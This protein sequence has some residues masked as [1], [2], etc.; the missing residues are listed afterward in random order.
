MAKTVI[1]V[2]STEELHFS[3]WIDDCLV[4]SFFDWSEYQP[5]PF[6]LSE[7][8]WLYSG[9]GKKIHIYRE[10]SY[11]PDFKIKYNETS[12]RLFDRVFKGMTLQPD[13]DFIYVDVKGEFVG[14]ANTSGIT[15]P[16]NQKWM[17]QKFGIIVY[18]VI[19]KKFFLKTW[20]PEQAA[21]KRGGLRRKPYEKCRLINEF[22][23]DQGLS[24]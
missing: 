6:I 13:N 8:V 5:K 3:H 1:E 4:R 22:I 17:F 14:Y 19:P 2:Q 16:L 20:V 11:Q 12:V 15:F 23:H 21:Y 24:L 10:H 18:K 7:P 9:T